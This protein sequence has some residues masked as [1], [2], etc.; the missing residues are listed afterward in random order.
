MLTTT[1]RSTLPLNNFTD[2]SMKSRNHV[3][4]R[5][6]YYFNIFMIVLYMLI[7]LMLIF[8]LNFL[9]IQP[10]N[11]IA[12]GAILILYAAYRTVK[13]IRNPGHYRDSSSTNQENES[14]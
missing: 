7:G 12:A 5:A 14:S 4:A 1:C 2:L 8:V 9:Q 13:L 3:A 6:Y 10:T 11:R